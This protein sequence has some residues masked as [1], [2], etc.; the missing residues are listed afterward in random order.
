MQFFEVDSGMDEY[1]VPNLF[2][3]FFWVSRILNLYTGNAGRKEER[4]ENNQKCAWAK[5]RKK[6]TWHTSL[7]IWLCSPLVFSQTRQWNNFQLFSLGFPKFGTKSSAVGCLEKSKKGKD[8]RNNGVIT[9]A[10]NNSN[11]GLG[12]SMGTGPN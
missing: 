7:L 1:W 11:N 5:C 4:R 3:F 6:F 8:R 10:N 12:S 2:F 9:K